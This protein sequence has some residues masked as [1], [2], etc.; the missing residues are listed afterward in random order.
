LLLLLLP[1]LLL[2]LLLLHSKS[3][4]KAASVTPLRGAAGGW[5]QLRVRWVPHGPLLQPGMPEGKLA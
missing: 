2:L 3:V 5:A 4:Q 1:L